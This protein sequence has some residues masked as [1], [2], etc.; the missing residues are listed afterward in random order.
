MDSVLANQWLPVSFSKDLQKDPISA[1]VLG[2]RVVVFRTAQGVKALKDL[3][4]HR[5]AALSQGKMIGDEIMCPYHGWR[6]D[7][8]GKCTAIPQQPASRQIPPKACAVPYGCTE[9]R[10]LVWVNLNGDDPATLPPYIEYEDP[11]YKTFFCGPYQ[12][13]ASMPRVVEN[14]LDVGHLAFLH[15]GSLGDPAHS[16]ITDYAVHKV[17]SRLVTDTISVFQPDPDGRGMAYL[18]DYVYEILKPSVVR[19]KKTGKHPSECY[20]M[21]LAV[22]PEGPV[23]SKAFICGSMN[24]NKHVTNEEFAERQ[25][26][27]FNEDTSVLE[28]QRPELLPLDL[29]EELHLPADRLSIAYRKM[30][31]EMNVSIGTA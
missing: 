23:S 3:C 31:K 12:V 29:Q 5:G 19:F 6:Y 17:D 24:Y 27:I 16:E 30:L 10:G 4:I 25:S 11:D 26:M 18:T 9:A 13:H 7:G 8:S 20:S 22:L 28:N 1:V 14:F 15:A 2:E 21:M